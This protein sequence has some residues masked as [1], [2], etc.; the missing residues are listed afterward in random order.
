MFEITA[1]DENLEAQLISKETV[2]QVKGLIEAL[3]QPE[4]ELLALRF[5]AGL[6]SA[7]IA[8]I[9]EKSKAATK[10]Q[11][12]RLQHRLR[13]QYHHQE[14]E[15]LLP[16]LLEPALPAFLASMRQAYAVVLP[17]VRLQDIRNNLLRQVNPILT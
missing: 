14:L 8:K 13:E 2:A 12:T 3:S 9:I 11:L 17:I 10:K 7:E 16:E 1:S 6:T 5:A 4:Q 15:E